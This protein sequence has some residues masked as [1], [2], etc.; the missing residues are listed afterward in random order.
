MILAEKRGNP[1]TEPNDE[2]EWEVQKNLNIWDDK[3]RATSALEELM[4]GKVRYLKFIKLGMGPE[5]VDEVLGR[6]VNETFDKN[7]S[8]LTKLG[9]GFL[10]KISKKTLLNKILTSFFINM[11]HMVNLSCIKKLEF[12][13]D[14]VDLVIQ[15]C[16]AKRAWKLGLKK[17]KAEELFSEETYC[18]KMCFP[19]F[20]KFL[21]VADAKSTVELQNRGCQHGIKSIK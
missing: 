6:F 15:K 7:M 13:P 12:Y 9:A 10:K 14:R 8:G 18:E 21:G 11:Q 4:E 16:T 2:V 19:T 1:M 3:R 20:N 17:N 5:A